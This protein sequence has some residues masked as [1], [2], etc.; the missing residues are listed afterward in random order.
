MYFWI[1]L[2]CFGILCVY[3]SNVVKNNQRKYITN[4]YFMI[5]LA[6]S[7]F[8][9]RIGADY[10][11]YEILYSITSTND[12]FQGSM[13]P[14]FCVIA[15]VFK[16]FGLNS[17]AM[18]LVYTT[19]TLVFVLIT[20][21]RY[22]GCEKENVIILVL[23]LYTCVGL[24]GG[25]WWGMNAMRQGAAV[26]I[27]FFASYY[28][29]QRNIFK[30][31]G[32]MILAF[33]FHYSAL[34]FFPAYFIRR[35]Q[36]SNIKLVMLIGMAL[37]LCAWMGFSQRLFFNGIFW[38]ADLYGKYGDALT[39]LSYVEGSFVY[40]NIIYLLFFLYSLHKEDAKDA[41]YVY[42]DGLSC[43]FIFIRLFTGFYMEGSSVMYLIHRLAPYFLFYYLLHISYTLSR[44]VIAYDKEKYML[45]EILVSISIIVIFV[46]I[47][48]K[49]IYFEQEN[50]LY[51]NVRG[52]SMGNIDYDYRLD[53]LEK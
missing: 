26:A 25:Y 33:M 29:Y 18:F 50:P 27:T 21:R 42:L 41:L 53:F 49:D 28:A 20:L 45:N 16:Y 39:L 10:D 13:E 1:M 7:S 34:I 17:Q 40:I 23:F 9:Y 36:K 31:F 30:Y 3:M 38:F 46:F 14:T 52:T 4:V 12:I 47:G 2:F 44:G 24:Q 6:I 32:T 43:C 48:C 51:K 37:S 15:E 22:L 11:E 5:I 19:V 35:K 8:R